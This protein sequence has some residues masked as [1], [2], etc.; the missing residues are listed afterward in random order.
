MTRSSFRAYP[1]LFLALLSPPS[2]NA[3]PI[4]AGQTTFTVF[5]IQDVELLPGTPFNPTGSSLVID[6]LTAFG[7]FTIA[8]Q[9]Q[10]GSTIA[11]TGVQSLFTGSHP[12]LGNF[13]LG[14]GPPLNV[15]SFLGVITNVMQDPL[16]PGFP[17]GQPSSFASGDM[18]L[19]VPAFA[20]RFQPSGVVVFTKDP[21]TFTAAL[22]GLPPSPGTVL[23]GD[24]TQLGVYFTD[25]S[26]GA[27]LLVG[28]ST[29]RRLVTSAVPEPA[30]LALLGAAAV[31][32]FGWRRKLGQGRH[33]NT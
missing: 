4:V 21:F 19:D 1:L 16:D 29:D 11:F 12:L 13:E 9:A 25:P 6:D 30:G 15:G 32:F 28:Y 23:Q 26:T 33:A 20:L 14:A 5:A 2:V 31:G 27:D 7:T 8:R 24:G 17:T 22:D 3:A 18:R 10:S